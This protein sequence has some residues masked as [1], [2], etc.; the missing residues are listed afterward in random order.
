MQL[1]CLRGALNTAIHI[2]CYLGITWITSQTLFAQTPPWMNTSLSPD[3]RASLL[4]AQMTLDEKIAMVHGANGDYIGNISGNS[5]LG[6]PELHLQD[7]P[8]GVGDGA[9]DITALPAPIALAA[10]WD[11]D[12]ARQYGAVMGVEARGKGVHVL[13]G[14]AMS[15]AR[16][17]QAG[18]NFEC[19]GED[20]FLSGAIASADVQG[21]QS[22]GVIATAK[23]FIGN[24]QETDRETE[25]SDVDERTLE[26]IY[27]APF[28]AS[29]R[30]GLGAVMGAFNQVN[31]TYA[32]ESSEINNVVKRLWNF[33]GFIMCDWNASFGMQSGAINGLDLEMPLDA[34]FGSPLKTAIQSGDLSLSRLDNMVHRI[35]ATMFRFGVFDTPTTGNL[36]ADVTSAA[37]TQ[38]AQD[39]AAQGIVLLK[40]AGAQLPL[41]TTSIHSIAVIGSAASDNVL[42]VGNGSG[43]VNLPY[44]NLPLDAIANRAGSSITTTYSLGDGGHIAEAVQLAQQS[45]VAIV[46]VGEQT[47]EGTDRSSLSL[48]DDQDAL[49]TAVAAANPHT[50]VVLYVDGGTLMPWLSQVPAVLVAW[51]PGQEN[52]NALASI[53]FG[54]VNPSGKL[55][56]TFPANASQ[57]PANTPA[58]FPG[59]NGHVSY[60]EQLLV[61]YRW[62]DALVAQP[63]FPFGHGLSYTTFAYSNLTMGA[64]SPSGQVSIGCDVYNT[65]SRAGSEVAQLYLGFPS[66]AGEPP[67]QLKGFKKVSLSPG[68]SAHV[69]FNLVWEDLACWDPLAH[70]WAVP[71][72]TFQVMVGSS[73]RDIRLTGSFNVSSPPQNSEVANLALHQPVTVSSTQNTSF[74]G[75]AATDGNPTTKW[76]SLA[77][78]SQSITVDLGTVKDI[79]RVRLHW[80]TNYA[81]SYQIL[82]S[83]NNVQWANI[84]TT[85]TGNGGVEDIVVKGSGRY[86]QLSATQSAGTQGYSLQEFEV[87]SP[88]PTLS[89]TASG[90]NT[91]VIRWSLSW[92]GFVLQQAPDLNSPSWVTVPGSPTIIGGMNQVILP[93]S[94]GPKF[95]RLIYP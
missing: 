91:F 44:F 27:Y 54:D 81:R 47:G 17:P 72:G 46:C 90:T 34:R 19:F 29:V 58:Q 67:R 5:R 18:R 40:N 64:V 82:A 68:A 73:S 10:S 84:Y 83:T 16:V 59:V 61:G 60:S 89:I 75:S 32:C 6:I 37:H 80:D 41:N 87:Y 43:A 71:P 13:L 65:G 57:V 15:M 30:S 51:Y 48:P 4:V 74:S 38:F 76:A 14:P 33:D 3:Q 12:L 1:L 7:G 28:R 77:S 24:E 52:G 42:S 49:I 35:L 63:L 62:Y 2:I 21:I 79:A 56:I 92:S 66:S 31:G 85:T 39:A 50:I 26:E 36:A 23:H 20:P 55:P 11:T 70:Q 95:Y 53:L 8:A 9:M 22:Q 94:Q 69:T 86:V 93:A 78:S 88:T 45:D 25:S